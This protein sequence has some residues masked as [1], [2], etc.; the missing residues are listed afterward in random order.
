MMEKRHLQE[1]QI[2]T[3][4]KLIQL[5]NKVLEEARKDFIYLGSKLFPLSFHLLL[6]DLLSSV[7]RLFQKL[8]HLESVFF[9]FSSI[10]KITMVVH[11]CIRKF[12]WFFDFEPI[13]SAA[14]AISK[15]TPLFKNGQNDS[16]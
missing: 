1:S 15:R 3:K 5:Q 4:L 12:I 16:N 9:Y 14:S 6:V 10:L 13:F 8:S 7:N 2:K 11:V